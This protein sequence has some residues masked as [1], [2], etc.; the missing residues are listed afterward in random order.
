MARKRAKKTTDAATTSVAEAKIQKSRGRGAWRALDAG[1][2][3]LAA[4]LAPRVSN[5]A[6]RAATGRKPPTNTRNPELSTKEAVA[7]AAIGG[8]TV[9]VVRTMARRSAANYWLRSTG[10]LPP[11]MKSLKD[12]TD[13]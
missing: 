3:L 7:W 11:G 2:G 4:S 10:D 8:A 1:S 6:W 12:P 5:L 9:Q 13:R